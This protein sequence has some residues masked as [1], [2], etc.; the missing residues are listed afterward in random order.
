MAG[1]ALQ[2]RMIPIR[3]LKIRCELVGPIGTC[4][5]EAT[6]N[7]AVNRAVS[8]IFLGVR[9][10]KPTYRPERVRPAPETSVHTGRMPSEIC[11]FSFPLHIPCFN[12]H[13]SSD[14]KWNRVS[15]SFG[16][17]LNFMK[18]GK[19]PPAC[20]RHAIAEFSICVC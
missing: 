11:N 3:P 16:C 20:T 15:V 12:P 19:S 17:S 10:L 2:P 6:K 18:C 4:I 1:I 8:G 5:N 9:C 14:F 7:P 13:Y